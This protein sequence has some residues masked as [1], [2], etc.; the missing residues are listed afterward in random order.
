MSITKT[1]DNIPVGKK[2]AAGFT[3]MVI[4]AASIAAVGINTLSLYHDRP[5]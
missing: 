4:L 2:L 5:R 3:F 1:L